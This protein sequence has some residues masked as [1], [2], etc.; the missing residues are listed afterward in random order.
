MHWL[1]ESYDPSLMDHRFFTYL[2][3]KQIIV[4]CC[5]YVK[6]IIAN[7][8]MKSILSYFPKL[9]LSEYSY[10][11]G[12]HFGWLVEGIQLAGKNEVMKQFVFRHYV[13]ANQLVNLARMEED[14]TTGN[15]GWSKLDIRHFY[16][17]DY[18]PRMTCK[19]D[20]KDKPYNTVVFIPDKLLYHQ[21][22]EDYLDMIVRRVIKPSSSARTIRKMSTRSNTAAAASTAGNDNDDDGNDHHHSKVQCIQQPPISTTV[23]MT[24]IQI[25]LR[26]PED[27]MDALRVF[28]DKLPKTLIDYTRTNQ[29]DYLRYVFPTDDYNEIV[30]KFKWI[31]PQEVTNSS[32]E[33]QLLA[34]H[35]SVPPNVAAIL[36]DLPKNHTIQCY[37]TTDDFD[38]L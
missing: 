36:Q 29:A 21:Q 22:R 12:F 23:K 28:T 20:A 19:V 11:G 7:D 25:A 16:L 13:I 6:E 14:T 24:Y 31:V 32:E 18:N 15:S 26:S 3:N 1:V 30:F 8:L 34:P 17:H 10:F 9:Q 37:K 4:P 35:H 27:Q 5:G 38:D 33:Q 2:P